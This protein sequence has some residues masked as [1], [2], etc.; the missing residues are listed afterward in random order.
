MVAH[1]SEPPSKERVERTLR[2]SESIVARSARRSAIREKEARR[3]RFVVA[4]AI[5]NLRSAGV[6]RR[7]S[8]RPASRP[9]S[10]R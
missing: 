10:R 5:R 7:T 2:E 4:R 9:R 8:K 1:A 3:S 6:L